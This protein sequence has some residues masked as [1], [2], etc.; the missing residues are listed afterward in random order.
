MFCKLEK[1]RKTYMLTRSVIDLVRQN[2]AAQLREFE[3][4]T[5]LNEIKIHLY[6]NH[7]CEDDQ[8]AIIHWI[9]NYGAGF[10]DYLNTIKIAAL[11]WCYEKNGEDFSEDEFHAVADWVNATKPFLD[12]VHK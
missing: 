4:K 5:Q 6:L 2:A 10:R 11:V 7:C 3:N 12:I 9:K 1:D 8:N